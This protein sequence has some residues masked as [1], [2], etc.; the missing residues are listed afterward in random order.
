MHKIKAIFSP[1]IILLVLFNG[2]FSV[3]IYGSVLEKAL[4]IDLPYLN[5]ISTTVF[6]QKMLANEANIHFSNNFK[7]VNGF[8]GSIVALRVP[9]LDVNIDLA[10]PV[11]YEDTWKISNTKA[12]IIPYSISHS[13]LLGNSLIFANPDYKVLDLLTMINEGDRLVIKTDKS[14]NYTYKVSKK[15]VTDVNFVPHFLY[16]SPSKVV[17]IKQIKEKGFT[18]KNMIIEADYVSVEEEI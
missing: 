12:Y 4:L 14:W 10:Y 17:I 16:S 6:P 18:D 9:K 11:L 3:F 7:A 2:I 8:Y 5:S 1:S 15:Y 13:G